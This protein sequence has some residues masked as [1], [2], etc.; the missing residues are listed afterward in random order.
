MNMDDAGVAAVLVTTIEATT[1]MTVT[2]RAAAITIT[3]DP[4]ITRLRHTVAIMA[5]APA[6]GLVLEVAVGNTTMAKGPLFG[7][8][9]SFNYPPICN[10]QAV[11]RIQL[12]R[13]TSVAISSTFYYMRTVMAG[14]VFR[15]EIRQW[16]FRC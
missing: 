9:F 15:R 12:D 16:R 2:I 6:L 11:A 14:D 10:L 7:V 3:E 4:A 13:H 1:T 8:A 5:G